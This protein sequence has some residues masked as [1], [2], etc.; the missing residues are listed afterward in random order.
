M[1]WD[2]DTYF[3][4]I[5]LNPH[6]TYVKYTVIILIAWAQI[7]SIINNRKCMTLTGSW[8][9]AIPHRILILMGPKYHIPQLA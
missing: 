9:E 8:N 2:P 5:L 6:M 4:D 7:R 1:S 3:K